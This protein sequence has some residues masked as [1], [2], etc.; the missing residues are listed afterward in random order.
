MYHCAYGDVP[1]HIVH[2]MYGMFIVDPATP[3]PTVDHEW[4]IV[5]S[6][7][8]VDRRRT[9]RARPSSTARR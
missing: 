3:L 1:A 6:E 8:Y 5:Q 9:P 4:A 7:W 2:G